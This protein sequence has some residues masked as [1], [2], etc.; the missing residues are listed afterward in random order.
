MTEDGT[1][2]TVAYAGRLNDGRGGDFC[3]AVVGVNGR[4]A[5]GNIELHIRSRDW[6]S[7]GHDRDAAYNSV[8]LH[9][10]VH[11]GAGPTIRED[12][13]AVPLVVLER[14]LSGTVSVAERSRAVRACRSGKQLRA[15]QLLLDEAGDLRY[16][17]KAGRF[18][19]E[20][21]RNGPA[22]A[23]YSG[24]MEALGYARNRDAF[25]DLAQRVPL[26]SLERRAA[27]CTD[28]EYE[29]EARRAL[30][31]STPPN[32][33]QVF[34]GR[35]LNSPPTRLKAMAGLLARYRQRGLLGGLIGTIRQ[36]GNVDGHRVLLGALAVD[37]P[38]SGFEQKERNALGQGRASTVI[39]NVLLPFASALGQSCSDEVLAR[40]ALEL[41]RA[42]PALPENCIERHMRGQLR[43]DRRAVSTARR[44][45]GLH[46]FY[47]ELCTQGG[48][49]SCPL[50]QPEVGHDIKIKPIT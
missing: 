6:V 15:L 10:A 17:K 8:I 43:L 41:Y 16:F 31:E 46:H 47:R 4:T 25:L 35:P 30:L 20:I 28:E 22:E 33:W 11:G 3:D 2:V 7:H 38:G 18:K 14:L 1:P 12:G 48:C 50:R 23:L 27:G 29:A 34:R 40:K 44:Q 19:E 9:V 21:A 24:I 26:S 45:Q 42:Y 49:V 32:G 5:R 13:V 39:V 37:R 36:A